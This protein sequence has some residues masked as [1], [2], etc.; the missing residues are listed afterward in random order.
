MNSASLQCG[1]DSLQASA[2]FIGDGFHVRIAHDSQH[3]QRIDQCDF[4][5]V[6]LDEGDGY[7]AGQQQTNLRR[8]GQCAIGQW[9]VARAEDLVRPEVHVEL[10]LQRVLDIDFREDAKSFRF[11][12]VDCTGKPCL[13]A[14]MELYGDTQ[15]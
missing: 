5:Q 2:R 9:G 4:G 6:F 12:R 11:E 14:G 3:G 15:G 10:V 13:I 1:S 7:I 8:G